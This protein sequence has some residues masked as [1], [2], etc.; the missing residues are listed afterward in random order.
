VIAAPPSFSSI[1]ADD[2]QQKNPAE[3]RRQRVAADSVV[4]HVDEKATS[5]SVDGDRGD[6]DLFESELSPELQLADP[7]LFREEVKLFNILTANG[8]V[9]CHELLNLLTT[10]GSFLCHE[11]LNILQHRPPSCP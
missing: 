2:A 4:E 9:L 1:G 6:S 8:S 3:E 5:A 7:D 10:N 11:L